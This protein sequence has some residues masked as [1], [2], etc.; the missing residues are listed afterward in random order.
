MNCELTHRGEVLKNFI[1]MAE[2]FKE[3]PP[4]IYRNF[5]LTEK[6]GDTLTDWRD[7]SSSNLKLL[8]GYGLIRF[9]E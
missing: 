1:E 2:V 5:M 3:I 4:E 6:A 8:E 7:I 9:N